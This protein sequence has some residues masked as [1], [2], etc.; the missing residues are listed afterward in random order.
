MRICKKSIISGIEYS[1]EIPVNP[2]DYHA[3]VN[4]HGSIDDLMPYLSAKDRD[5]ILSGISL[6]E[7]KEAFAE[8]ID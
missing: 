7:W 2:D 5:F 4:G 1:K 3:W 6:S 8:L